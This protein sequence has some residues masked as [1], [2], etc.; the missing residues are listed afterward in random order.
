MPGAAKEGGKRGF[1]Q[2]DPSRLPPFGMAGRVWLGRRASLLHIYGF[3]PRANLFGEN[4]KPAGRGPGGLA[5]T[6]VPY[7]VDQ[8]ARTGRNVVP[9][10]ER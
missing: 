6:K 9:A 8:P 4:K 10:H 1:D 3:T 5:R 7:L 2:A